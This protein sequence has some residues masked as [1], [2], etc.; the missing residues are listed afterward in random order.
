MSNAQTTRVWVTLWEAPP[1]KGYD[2]SV[3]AVASVNPL[4][5]EGCDITRIVLDIPH[6][7]GLG[8]EG[9]GDTVAAAVAAER[10]RCAVWLSDEADAYRSNGN[11][12]VAAALLEAADD[13]RRGDD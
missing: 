5:M 3:R 13:L 10:E 7:V 9:P 8:D 6:G 11:V 4:R 1:I 12:V 2:G